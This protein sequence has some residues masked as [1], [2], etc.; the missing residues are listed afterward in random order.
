LVLGDGGQA[1]LHPTSDNNPRTFTI[2][3]NG[4]PDNVAY[5]LGTV[6]TFINQINTVTIAIT[7]DTLTL[8]PAGTTGTRTL[9]A[10]NLATATKITSTT[11]IITGTSGL[12]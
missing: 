11:W 3:A 5:P 7:S 10:N 12:T 2:P 1:I 6:I 8:Y 4:S 9:A